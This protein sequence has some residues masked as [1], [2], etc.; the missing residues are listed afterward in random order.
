MFQFNRAMFIEFFLYNIYS[1][2]NKMDT[3]ELVD[4][5]RNSCSYSA[6]RFFLIFMEPDI[7]LCKKEQICG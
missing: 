5:T 3:N 2:R 4:E 7:Q 1:E 6:D